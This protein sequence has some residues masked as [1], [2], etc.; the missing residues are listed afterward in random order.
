MQI[1]NT[2]YSLFKDDAF[3]I[4]PDFLNLT[5]KDCVNEYSDGDLTLQQAALFDFPF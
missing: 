1:A 3:T 4:N 5:I 2:K